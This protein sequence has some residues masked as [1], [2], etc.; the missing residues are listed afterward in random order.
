MYAFFLPGHSGDYLGGSYVNKTAF[1]D[2]TDF[3]LANHLTEKYFYFRK[4]NHKEHSQI[5][6]I[7]SETLKEYI[8]FE[9]TVIEGKFNQTVEDWDIKEKLAKFIVRSCFV[10]TFFGYEHYL[11][12]WDIKLLN[13]FRMIPF[14]YRENKKLY[15]ECL[16]QKFFI[17]EQIYFGEKEIKSGWVKLYYQ[18]FKDNI[19]YFFPWKI[20]LAKMKKFDWMNYCEFTKEMNDEIFS[21]TGRY[22][23]NFKTFNAVICRWYLLILKK[24]HIEK[25]KI[26]I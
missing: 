23:K 24:L 17:P 14:K 1:T 13:Y 10:F 6:Q 20:V 7:I 21:E 3:K 2:K 4:K 16:I 12:Y 9:N 15:D 11:V 8:A 18:K 5:R 19:R 25:Q 22:L 26:E